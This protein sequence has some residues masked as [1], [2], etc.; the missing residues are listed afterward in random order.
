MLK[1]TL[2]DDIVKAPLYNFEYTFG[3]IYTIQ[4]EYFK[5]L[6]VY[7]DGCI[8][9]EY[10]FHSFVTLSDAVRFKWCL[11]NATRQTCEFV[12]VR[13]IIPNGAR[14]YTGKQEFKR[15]EDNS[16]DGYC[17]EAI[18]IDEIVNMTEE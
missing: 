5:D 17:S 3:Q 9:A 13:C 8:L 2:E 7:D 16:S 4:N 18:R 10:G 1:K 14:Y 12:I 6:D 15:D 11:S